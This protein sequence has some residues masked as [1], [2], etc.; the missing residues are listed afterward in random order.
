MIVARRSGGAGRAMYE[1][2]PQRMREVG[3]SGLLFSGDRQEG[4]LFPGASM[5]L[6]PPGRAQ[7]IRRGRKPQLIQVAYLAD[8]ASPS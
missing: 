1:P 8:P 4:A 2:V 6:L 5:S 7:L 3:S